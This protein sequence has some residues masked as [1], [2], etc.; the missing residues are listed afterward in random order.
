MKFSKSTFSALLFI[1]VVSHAD[2]CAGALKNAAKCGDNSQPCQACTSI[3]V[4]KE[5]PDGG[6]KFFNSCCENGRAKCQTKSK[7]GFL[8]VTI[9]GKGG[10]LKVDYD[11]AGCEEYTRNS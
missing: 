9:I 5:Y 10:S 3:P 1:S 4:S 6:V 8:K 11:S 7:A 2:T